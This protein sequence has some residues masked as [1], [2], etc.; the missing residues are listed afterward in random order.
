[1]TLTVKRTPAPT[2][3]DRIRVKMAAAKMRMSPRPLDDNGDPL[4]PQLPNDL[5]QMNDTAL[6]ALLT[7]FVR[8]LQWAKGVTAQHDVDA[9][10][11]KRRDKIARAKARIRLG[12]QPGAAQMIEVDP[13]VEAASMDLMVA[14][15]AAKLSG[16]VYE[17]YLAARD[18][19]SRE[20]TRRIE[21]EQHRGMTGEAPR[22]RVPFAGRG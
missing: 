17:G 6:G 8:V 11:A 1:M 3:L 20:L 12:D 18:G 2:P 16:A 10:E 9:A 4:D 7:K 13:A 15:G 19:I 5:T 14:E 22:R 21:L